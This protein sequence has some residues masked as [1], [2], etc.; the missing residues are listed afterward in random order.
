MWTEEGYRFSWWVMLT[1]KEGLATF[2]VQDKNSNR[3]WEVTNKEYLTPF[4]EKRMSIRPDHILQYAH[5]LE[6]VYQKKYGLEKPRI[7]ADV[8]VTMNGRMSQRLIDNTIDLSRQDLK[9]G[10][11]T[12]VISYEK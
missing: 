1:E 10:H 8:F 11:N 2:Y 9:L 6:E 7:T 5:Y 3:K 4:Q 12:W